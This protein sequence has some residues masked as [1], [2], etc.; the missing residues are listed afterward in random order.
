M[1]ERLEGPA[2]VSNAFLVQVN[3]AYYPQR[4]GK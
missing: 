3:S 4:G 1:V 2:S